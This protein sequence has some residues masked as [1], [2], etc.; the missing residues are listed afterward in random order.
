MDR[1]QIGSLEH[2]IPIV[3]ALI[4]GAIFI[5]ASRRFLTKKEQYRAVHFLAILISLAL[6]AFHLYYIII[7]DYNYRTD[8]PL[9]LCSFLGLII[10]FFTHYRKFWMYEILLFWI[11]AGTSQGVIT[12]DISEGFPSLDYFRYWIVHLGLLTVILY[13]TF[14]YP[15]RPT[16]KSVFKSILMF[17]LYVVIMLIVNKMLGSNY[18]YL[19]HKPDSASLLDYFGEWPYYLL[20]VQLLLIPIF[21]LI[22]L[23][24]FLWKKKKSRVI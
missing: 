21:L 16:I 3:L 2:L 20:V 22:Y 15:M 1:V 6:I 23:P 13:A 18:S 14:V 24:F 10:P 7:G 5:W 9:F 17:Q 8:L 12:P 4:G 19:N 11:V